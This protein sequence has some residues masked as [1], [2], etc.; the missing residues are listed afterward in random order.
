MHRTVE[1]ITD[2]YINKRINMQPVICNCTPGIAPVT[3][4]Q[5]TASDQSESNN[6]GKQ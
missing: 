4:N 6:S 1:I 2:Y 3:E 5:T